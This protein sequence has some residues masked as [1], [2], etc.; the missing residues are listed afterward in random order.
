MNFNLLIAGNLFLIFYLWLLI[1]VC[2]LIIFNSPRIYKKLRYYEEL[3]KNKKREALC[4]FVPVMIS[5]SS[6]N[7][8]LQAILNIDKISKKA[9][10]YPA[11]SLTF[12]LL[13]FFQSLKLGLNFVKRLLK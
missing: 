1:I 10:L 9:F 13:T 2:A 7:K 6:Y 12:N 5:C 3:C 4:Y 8:K 11:I